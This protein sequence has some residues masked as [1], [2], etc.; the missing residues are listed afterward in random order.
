MNYGSTGSLSETQNDEFEF[1]YSKEIFSAFCLRHESKLHGLYYPCPP[2]DKDEAYRETTIKHDFIIT[3][4]PPELWKASARLHIFL[5][6]K[7]STLNQLCTYLKDKKISIIHSESSRSAYRYATWS[8]HIVFEE[9]LSKKLEYIESESCYKETKCAVK[10][11][12]MAFTEDKKDYLYIPP[13]LDPVQGHPN[14]S[15]AYFANYRETSDVKELYK[16]PFTLKVH[17]GD[18]SHRTQRIKGNDVLRDIMKELLVEEPDLLPCTTF[19]EIDTNELNLRTVLI[20]QEN[21]KRFFN[22]A[23][24]YSCREKNENGKQNGTYVGII[25]AITEQMPPQYNMWH[26]YDRIIDN[27]PSEKGEFVFLIENISNFLMREAPQIKFIKDRLKTDSRDAK[28][29]QTEAANYFE[30]TIR[31]CNASETG[32]FRFDKLSISPLP[33]AGVVKEILLE[34]T[35]DF[36]CDLF[37]SYSHEDKTF[38]T[39]TLTKLLDEYGVS[40]YLDSKAIESGERF[41][42]SLLDNIKKSREMCVVVS[43]N[44]EKSN[45]MVIER[46]AAWILGK[47]ITPIR[48]EVEVTIPEILKF[49]NAK[50]G[51]KPTELQEYAEHIVARRYRYLAKKYVKEFYK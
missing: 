5:K 45:W 15:L 27:Q 34:E 36:E 23:I 14:Y 51:F 24:K 11:L 49:H 37:I 44:T 46:G 2:A 38:V 35:R 43:K 25:N 6:N 13:S 28:S 19:S 50:D 3:P 41:D 16:K 12:I 18:R 33:T 22:V 26:A 20:S 31:K 7:P 48:K 17:D 9:L 40:Y 32:E 4:I 10:E 1:A 42:H 21:A 39:D 30:N 29:Y 8:L 47:H